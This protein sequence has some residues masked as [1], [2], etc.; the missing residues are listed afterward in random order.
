ME[1]DIMHP[2]GLQTAILKM[3]D[4][5]YLPYQRR[6]QP[7][8]RKAEEAWLRYIRA[9]KAER[10]LQQLQNDAEAE[11][12]YNRVEDSSESGE[13][14]ERP[15]DSDEEGEREM[16]IFWTHQQGFQNEV[17]AYAKLKDLQGKYIPR[18]IDIVTY[19][20]QEIP[21]D[22]PAKFFDIPGFLIEFIPKSIQLGD[23]NTTYPNWPD[24]W[25]KIVTQAKHVA[26]VVN[27]AGIVTNDNQPRN[28]LVTEPAPGD[29][30]VYM[31]DF[32]KVLFREHFPDADDPKNEWHWTY[33][34][35]MCENP[36]GIAIIMKARIRR[37][38]K[39]EIDVDGVTMV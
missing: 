23:I 5:R 12:S 11:I 3:F 33:T 13:E 36:V 25:E 6:K 37:L 24:V 7:Y 20:Q 15:E 29:Y 18:F 22:A 35:S 32:T 27:A 31:I 19:K 10:D 16:D 2:K 21:E 17:A 34:V 30:R 26:E 39:V 28:Y 14:E 38:E 9:G 4:R 8:T 1:V